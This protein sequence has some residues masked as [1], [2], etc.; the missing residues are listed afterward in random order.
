M[1]KIKS[2]FIPIAVMT[3]LLA[4]SGCSQGGE[5]APPLA[6]TEWKLVELNGREPLQG[7]EVT[8]I[9]DEK[10]GGGNS[11]CNSYGG[12]YQSG[13]DGKLEF[14]E[15]EQTLMFCMEP[16]GVMDQE[17][18][19]SNLLLQAANYRITNERLEIQ[20]GGGN[21]ILKYERQ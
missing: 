11:S 18:E 2:V 13:P 4:M 10:R 12:E 20:D 7:T 8:L 3:L 5:Q 19:Y 15:I 16:E 1:L 9:F 17:T 14:G 21:T 6:G